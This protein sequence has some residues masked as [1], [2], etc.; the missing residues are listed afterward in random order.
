MA[1]N[2]FNPFFYLIER[3]EK[4]VLYWKY[5]LLI[6]LLCIKLCLLSSLEFSSNM[7]RR[8]SGNIDNN[9]SKNTRTPA[10]MSH[11]FRRYSQYASAIPKATWHISTAAAPSL[12]TPYAYH[13]RKKLFF[14]GECAKFQIKIR[15]KV[16]TRLT[17]VNSLNNSILVAHGSSCSYPN[18]VT[19][20]D[21]ST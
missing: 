7:R 18:P 13:G 19:R 9:E 1:K 3:R 6:D 10:A 16:A 17:S 4:Q 20:R 14:G 11:G 12:L 2:T 15:D 8:V 21:C 5:N